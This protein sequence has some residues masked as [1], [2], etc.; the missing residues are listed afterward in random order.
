VT[1]TIRAFLARSKEKF[2]Y[3]AFTKE[4]SCDE[5]RSSF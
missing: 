5:S 2:P 1:K 3:E 4:K